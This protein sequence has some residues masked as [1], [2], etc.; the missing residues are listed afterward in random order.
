[1]K[2]LKII[3]L[4]KQNEKILNHIINIKIRIMNIKTM[5]NIMILLKSIMEILKIIWIIILKKL[6][7]INQKLL[8]N[9][10]KIIIYIVFN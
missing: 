6:N 10:S 1:M 9:T 8:Q 2:I 3:G 5:I 7:S 4:I